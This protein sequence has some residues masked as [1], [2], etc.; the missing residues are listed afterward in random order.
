MNTVPEHSGN[1]QLFSLG[2]RGKNFLPTARDRLT[3]GDDKQDYKL[4]AALP[5]HR[6]NTPGRQM[7]RECAG[8]EA[9][10]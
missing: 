3:D 9:H 5:T 7:V 1:V 8:V 6:S 10:R 2:L 4:L